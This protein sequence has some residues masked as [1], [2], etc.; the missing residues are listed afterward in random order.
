MPKVFVLTISDELRAVYATK[1]SFEVFVR[2][3][4]GADASELQ[5]PI[6]DLEKIKVKVSV[7]DFYGEFKKTTMLKA[8][9]ALL[10][11]K[12]IHIRYK[13][14]SS[15][16]SSEYVLNTMNLESGK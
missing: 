4:V 13:D 15:G 12:I 14:W 11:H 2:H 6:S 1:P 7:T 16:C 5:L 9:K 3:V 8:Y 10:K